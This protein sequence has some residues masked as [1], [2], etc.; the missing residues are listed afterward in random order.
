[1]PAHAPTHRWTEE[2]FYAARDAAPA[3]ERWELFVR[4][5]AYVREQRIGTAYCAPLDVKLEPGLVMQPDVLVVPAGHLRQHDDIVRALLLAAEVISPSSARFDRVI[6]RPRYQR[7]K[8]SEYCVIDQEAET[9]ERWQPAD[10]RPAILSERLTWH[11]SAAAV[12]FE[13]DIPAFFRE[14]KPL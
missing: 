6:K 7:H 1:M 11:P 10:E 14:A 12:P 3:G 2:E 13:L 9:F 5:H 8:V 4:L